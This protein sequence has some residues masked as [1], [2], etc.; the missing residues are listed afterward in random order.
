MK[1]IKYF[2]SYQ[3]Q[4]KDFVISIHE[5]FGFPYNYELDYDLDDPDKY[6]KKQGGIFYLLLDNKSLIGTVAIRNL[7][8]RKGELKRLYLKKEFRGK[9]LG[10]KLLN[11]V[12]DFC[13]K[14]DFAKIVLDT[15]KKQTSAQKLYKR[16]GFKV[17]SE[18]KNI[19]FMSKDL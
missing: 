3:K 6:Y 5:E 4:V 15:N 11:R 1:I 10:S 18:V 19:I 17:E 13:R 16:N 12:L 9:G 7:G 2:P 8:N 14:N